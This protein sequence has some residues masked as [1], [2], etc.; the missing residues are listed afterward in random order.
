M[1]PPLVI[2]VLCLVVTSVYTG[3][4]SAT[5]HGLAGCYFV[6]SQTRDEVTEGAKYQSVVNYLNLRSGDNGTYTVDIR[7]YGDNW[8]VCAFTDKVA[9]QTNG[10]KLSLKSVNSNKIIGEYPEPV[11]CR[12]SLAITSSSI[13][14]D[15]FSDEC[16]A[17]LGCG[18]KAHVYG[19]TFLRNSKTA[20]DNK[21]CKPSP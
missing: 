3:S 9:L 10:G 1:K 5:L 17:I 18:S 6:K 13:S 12:L 21:L 14:V 7:V 11:D 8:H 15:K 16:K 4:A 2:I 19:L 20:N